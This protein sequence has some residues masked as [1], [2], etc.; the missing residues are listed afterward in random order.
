PSDTG[1]IDGI[2][3]KYARRDGLHA[4]HYA[5]APLQAGTGVSVEVDFGR[6]FDHMQQHSGQH[7]LSA[8]IE[9]ECGLE[10]V[11][12]NLGVDICHVEL[13]TSKDF[14]FTTAMME[15]IEEKCNQAIFKGLPMTT[16]VYDQDSEK[17]PTSVPDDY[18]GGVIRY[19]EI[20]FSD[21]VLDRNA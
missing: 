10:T 8:L 12:W 18:V 14:V 16:H 5:T 20:G 3:V 13:G 1:Y 7:L 9:R 19:V 4:I 21:S 2:E 11:S 17:V 6:R 15:D